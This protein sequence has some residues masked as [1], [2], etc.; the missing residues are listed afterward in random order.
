[1]MQYK[2]YIGKVE[3]DDEAK[4]LHGEV[5]GLRD[6][7]TFQADSVEDI[8]KEFQASVDDYLAFC[9]ER[10][11][12]PEKPCSGQ[13]VIRADSELH[14]YLAMLAQVLG[15]SL[16]TLVVEFLRREVE[17]ALTKVRAATQEKAKPTKPTKPTPVA[18]KGAAGGRRHV[19]TERREAVHA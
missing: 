7:V 14:R 10:G 2:N 5:V 4:I 6:V 11:E 12:E 19:R 8:E 9:K 18:Q 16:N 15:K 13:F 3:F 17:L 1:M